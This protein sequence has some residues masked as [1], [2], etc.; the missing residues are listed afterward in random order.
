MNRIRAGYIVVDSVKQVFFIALVVDGVKF[1]WV[2]KPAAVQSA[3]SNEVSPLLAAEGQPETTTDRAKAAIGRVNR[4]LRLGHS[5][6]RLRR[7]LNHQARFAAVFGWGASRNRFQRLNGIQGNLVREDL[8]LLIRDG[9]AINGERIL[10]VISKPVE[11]AIR[12]RYH[13]RR[14]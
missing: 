6:A 9:L 4:A 13:P 8:A 12:V 14:R 3:R 5:E 11:E 1:R 7:H 10:G 2:E